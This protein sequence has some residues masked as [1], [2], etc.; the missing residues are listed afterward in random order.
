MKHQIVITL[1]I[2]WAPDF[3]INFV[4]DILVE[5]NVKETWFVTH[6]SNYLKELGKNKLFELG[7]HPNFANTSTQGN[8]IEEILS[9][10]KKLCRILNQSERM[11]YTNLL[12]YLNN[13]INTDWKTMYRYS[14]QILTLRPTT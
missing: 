3:M 9:Y 14:Y 4:K 13:F 2:D 1:D 11:A 6:N 5:N 7:I 8:S 12:E 10:L